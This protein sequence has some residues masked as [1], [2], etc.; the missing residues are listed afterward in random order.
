VYPLKAVAVTYK[1]H[2]GKQRTMDGKGVFAA[3]V[4]DGD[5]HM[6]KPFLYQFFGRDDWDHRLCLMG[7]ELYHERRSQAMN[8]LMWAL[9]EIMSHEVYGE[10]GHKDEL[11]QDMLDLHAPKIVSKFSGKAR[12]VTTSQMD[13]PTM[14]SFIE[15]IFRELAEMGVDSLES[16]ASITQYWQEWY[17]WRGQQ[18]VDP[19]AEAYEGIEDYRQSVLYCEACHKF[20]R[21]SDGQVAHIVSKGAGGADA[22]WNL[23]KLCT[24]DHLFVQHQKG[25]DVFLKRYP[26]LRFRV[27]QARERA[28]K[29]TEGGQNE[30]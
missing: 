30:S 4:H 28:G 12:N 6:L 22:G 18:K 1:D 26:H 10:P 15:G 11:Y 25:W 17:A 3:Y 29:K 20:Q 21:G 5:Y 9:L 14:S 7:I 13:V 2:D 24:D 8:R 23:L 27:E 19:M 16:A